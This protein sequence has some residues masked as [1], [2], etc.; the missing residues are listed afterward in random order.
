M[1]MSA[2][3][4]LQISLRPGVDLSIPQV[5]SLSH[6][7]SGPGLN[8]CLPPPPH[9]IEGGGFI[10]PLHSPPQQK[11]LYE[12][13]CT[14]KYGPCRQGVWLRQVGS[15]WRHASGCVAQAG[16]EYVTPCLRVC[17]SGRWGVCDA[18]PQPLFVWPH[19]FWWSWSV[20]TSSSRYKKN[21]YVQEKQVCTY[22]LYVRTCKSLSCVVRCVCVQKCNKVCVGILLETL[23]QCSVAA[24][25][26][27]V[28]IDTTIL[29]TGIQCV[30][31]L[32]LAYEL[33]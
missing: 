17:G 11:I 6:S 27:A 3:V 21:R 31:R 26:V 5:R 25:G 16:G 32:L 19:R 4:K 8:Y 9:K 22:T 24:R 15:M 30:Y 33:I 2:A 12:I 28:T 13:L 7:I 1:P 10:D 29:Y 23:W 20:R 14:C 18:M